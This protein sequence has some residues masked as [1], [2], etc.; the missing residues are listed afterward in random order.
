ML[1]AVVVEI[2]V[3]QMLKL[4]LSFMKVSVAVGADDILLPCFECC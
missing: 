4:H 3:T 1:A 2:A